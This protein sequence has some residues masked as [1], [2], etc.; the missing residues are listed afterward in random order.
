[1]NELLK[2]ASIGVKVTLGPAFAS[3]GAP[4]RAAIEGL[5]AQTASLVAS[6]A[7]FKT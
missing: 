4:Q 1:M 3:L 7:R 5:R 2:N 6:Q